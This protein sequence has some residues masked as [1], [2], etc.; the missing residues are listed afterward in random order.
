MGVVITAVFEKGYVEAEAV[1]EELVLQVMIL[2]KE[3]QFDD[4][5]RK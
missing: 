4:V 5:G 1:I 2:Y 3:D